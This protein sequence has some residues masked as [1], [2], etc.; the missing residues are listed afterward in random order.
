[1][2]LEPRHACIGMRRVRAPTEVQQ[3]VD[4]HYATPYHWQ[5]QIILLLHYSRYSNMFLRMAP[6]SEVIEKGRLPT[7]FDNTTKCSDTQIE[8][9]A[10][11][12]EYC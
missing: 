2:K 6:K 7:G 3:S 8:M 10:A 11:L 12:L 5:D 1:L 9:S 4:V